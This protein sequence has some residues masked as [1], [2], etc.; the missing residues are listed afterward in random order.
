MYPVTLI[1][2][3][4]GNPHS[5]PRACAVLPSHVVRDD[6]YN[7]KGQFVVV[8]VRSE[9]TWKIAAELNIFMEAARKP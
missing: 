6:R 7:E 5:A 3:F 9:G 8:R 1:L 2:K 4:R